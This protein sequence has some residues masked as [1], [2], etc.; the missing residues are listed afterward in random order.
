MAYFHHLARSRGYRLLFS[1]WAEGL[2]LWRVVL[3][4]AP[5]PLALCLMPDHVHLLCGKDVRLELAAALSGFARH[6]G[7]PMFER[8]P[9]AQLVPAGLKL[10]R[11][12][13]YIHLN[14][15]RKQLVGDPLAWPLS[16]H[17][18]AVGLALPP[19]RRV[20]PDPIELHRYV[21]RDATVRV[22]GTDLPVAVDRAT[23]EEVLVAVSA[24]TR[25]PLGELGRRGAARKL[26]IAA[27]WYWA[28]ASAAELA[29]HLPV[30]RSTLYRNREVSRTSLDVVA[31]AVGDPRFRALGA[32]D[33]RAS[34][35]AYRRWAVR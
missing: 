21:T 31:R 20:H 34:W 13:R 10:E 8:L 14:P 6:R 30:G 19:V 26:A 15:C 17:R 29:V 27:G 5:S 33:L 1:T 35:G 2:A 32:E 9:P 28:E 25:T 4:V 18:D 16:T 12:I 24:V 22:E 7:G 11:M 23:I 3:R